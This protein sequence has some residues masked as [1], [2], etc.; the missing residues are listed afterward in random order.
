[1]LPGIKGDAEVESF[2][3]SYFCER[4]DDEFSVLVRT[5][6]LPNSHTAP[7]ITCAETSSAIG[8]IED[9]IRGY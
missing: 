9:K 4:C 1:M 3:G 7:C 2:F 6:N 5:E 8:Y